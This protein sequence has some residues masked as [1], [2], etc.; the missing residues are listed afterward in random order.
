MLND[1]FNNDLDKRR[2]NL[3]DTKPN[4]IRI[5]REFEEMRENDIVVTIEYCTNCEDH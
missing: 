3:N 1:N 4:E 5:F 2:I